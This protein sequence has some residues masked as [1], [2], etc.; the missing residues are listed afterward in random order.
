MFFGLV[1]GASGGGAEGT[2]AAKRE[3]GKVISD[4]RPLICTL[5]TAQHSRQRPLFA[6]KR[7]RLKGLAPE[8]WHILKSEARP[9]P[10]ILSEFQ[11]RARPGPFHC[12]P[13]P[14]HSQNLRPGPGPARPGCNS[15]DDPVKSTC[16]NSGLY[17]TFLSKHK[18]IIGTF[19]F[20]STP[21]P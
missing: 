5:Y 9:W 1:A 13:G 20:F 14:F 15:D 6:F 7:L 4:C 11:A 3:D 12:G 18:R 10:V 21:C 19:C 17:V 2:S 16:R 8:F